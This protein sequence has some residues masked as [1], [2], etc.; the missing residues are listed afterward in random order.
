MV[1]RPPIPVRRRVIVSLAVLTMPV[2]LPGCS[3]ALEPRSDDAT[4]IANLW[5]VMLAIST[6]VTVIVLALLGYALF[7]RRNPSVFEHRKL[8]APLFILV[9]G[10]VLPLAILVPVFG[11]SLFVTSQANDSSPSELVIEVVAHRFGYV[12]NYPSVGVS[13]NDELHIPEHRATR[14]NITSEDVIH[15]FWAPE[16]DGKM[17][18][19]PGR[20]TV[21]HIEDP[22][23]GTYT[24]RCA[25]F[26]GVDHALMRIPVVV[27]PQASFE[28]WVAS[29]EGSVG[30]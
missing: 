8:A 24:A 23:A 28:V 7:R 30:R 13:S 16:L 6:L 12:V 4:Q 21:I 20:T 14:L 9:G 26:C 19:F 11:Y 18:M 1:S 22:L 17:D 29:Q 10:G 25:E 27:E 15:S 2:L 3:G 5:W